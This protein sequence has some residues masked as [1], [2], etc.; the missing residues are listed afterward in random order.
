MI[1]SI[2]AESDAADTPIA[3][4]LADKLGLPVTIEAPPPGACLR[5]DFGRRADQYRTGKETIYIKNHK[6]SFLKPCPGTS[7][8]T[9]CGY[10]FLNIATNCPIDCVYCIL[11]DY[12]GPVPVTIHCNTDDMLAELEAVLGNGRRFL[13]IGTGE[14]TDS[15]AIDELTAYSRELVPFFAR[16]A[17][18]VLELKTKTA[19]VDNLTGLEHGGRTIVAWSLNPEELAETEE[20]G[21][22]PVAERI[23][24][25]KSCQDE[26]YLLAFHFDPIIEY[27]AWRDGYR[28]VVEMLFD[29]GIRQDR[30]AWVSLGCLRF[31]PA[32]REIMAQRFPESVSRTGEFVTGRDGKMRYFKPVRIEMYSALSEFFRKGW[33][34]VFVYLC[35]ESRSVW[36]TSLGRAPTSAELAAA[37]DEQCLRPDQ[38]AAG[39]GV[40][41]NGIPS[42]SAVG[43]ASSR[44]SQVTAR[45]R[46]YE[47][48]GAV[49]IFAALAS[50]PGEGAIGVIE[51]FGPAAAE[52]VDRVF[53]SPGGR[54][55]TKSR[56]DDLFYGRIV[57]ADAI[58]D[59]VLVRVASRDP[60]RLEINCHGGP[61]PHAAVMAL[62][63][64]LGVKKCA[65]REIVSLRAESCGLDTI[66]VE[67]AREIPDALTLTSS[68]ML[69]AQYEGALSEVVSSGDLVSRREELLSLAPYGIALCQP[70]KT[71]VA[72]RPNVGKSTLTNALLGHK[73]MIESSIAGTTRDAVAAFLN[74]EGVPLELVDTAGL[75][76]ARGELETLAAERAGAVLAEAGLALC[77]LDGSVE[78][79][80]EDRDL[81]AAYSDK[82]TIVV[83][84]KEDL[85]RHPSFD[86][87][88]IASPVRCVSVS[89]AQRTGLED[90]KRAMLGTLFSVVP[91]SVSRPIPFTER[92]VGLLEELNESNA[93]AIADK[94][95]SG[96]R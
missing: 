89:A 79:T 11:Q 15:L 10:N 80:R 44:E 94:L 71:V 4:R 8:H 14:L 87:A 51:V 5:R 39:T 81:L 67:A 36:R 47:K 24:A 6:G 37:L 63:Q 28:G 75:G 19:F 2:S 26:G 64:D 90:L 76:H 18:A 70:P 30:I 40:V 33:P 73:R 77:V 96:S 69:A 46:S 20:T 23:R 16:Y 21:A 95:L 88:K 12:L 61:A 86:E 92:Q 56:P 1:R 48:M 9:C 55:L 57:D 38:R 74:L 72:G 58:V 60:D 85:P 62:L 27:P 7:R 93:A 66:Q 17:N 82:N 52:T 35:M 59:E 45:C 43:A 34:D 32:M 49:P 42:F 31:V 53:R 25:A 3:R 50:P 78:I 68:M 84:N 22:A 91:E 65:W 13:R 41:G 83:I 29:A 54:T